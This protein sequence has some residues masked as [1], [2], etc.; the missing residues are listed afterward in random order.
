MI[1]S[2]SPRPVDWVTIHNYV[3]A[4]SPL[5]L[6]PTRELHRQ[7][8]Q[9][10]VACIGGINSLCGSLRSNRGGNCIT[11]APPDAHGNNISPAVLKCKNSSETTSE[12]RDNYGHFWKQSVS[13]VAR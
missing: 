8:T 6:H 9:V 4:Q 7:Q 13:I 11:S 3:I 5:L 10:D 12:I 2:L 1:R